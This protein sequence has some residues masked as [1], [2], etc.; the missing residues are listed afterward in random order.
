MH[1]CYGLDIGDKIIHSYRLYYGSAQ[2]PKT[3][4]VC[5]KLWMFFHHITD[6]EIKILAKAYKNNYSALGSAIGQRQLYGDSTDHHASI[7]E[8]KE[9]CKEC[10]IEPD[11]DMLKMGVFNKNQ[12]DT[13]IWFRDHF[14]IA[15]DPQP[16]G[17]QVHLDK[18]EKSD[19]YVLYVQEVQTNCLTFSAWCKFWKNDFPEVAIRKWKNVSGKCED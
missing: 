19:L 18:I 14:D 11:S 9:Y 17:S 6:H 1:T 3:V 13:F 8:L 7:Q 10:G 2:T 12:L 16:N 5:R 15:G 4:V